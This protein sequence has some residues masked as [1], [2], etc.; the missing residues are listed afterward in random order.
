MSVRMGRGRTLRNETRLMIMLRLLPFSVLPGVE[1]LGADEFRGTQ[2][3]PGAIRLA[4]A[5]LELRHLGLTRE[6][7]GLHS[8]TPAGART[9]AWEITHRMDE[10]QKR[11]GPAALRK[12]E[13]ALAL[14]ITAALLE[15]D[16][17]PS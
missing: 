4:A 10:D 6:Q 15:E 9:L 1:A 7:D 13:Y 3:V 14:Q 11:M 12:T 8:P 16:E 5:L 2:G 17:A